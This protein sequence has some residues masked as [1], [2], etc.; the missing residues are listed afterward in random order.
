M[1]SLPP[2]IHPDSRN[3]LPVVRRD[4][5]EESVRI[6]YDE[7][8]TRSATSVAGLQG[9]GGIMLNSPALVAPHR[10]YNRALRTLPELGPALTELAILVAARGMD[11]AFEW[12]T[13]EREALQAGLDARTIEVVRRGTA[14]STA[15]RR[16]RQS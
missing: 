6:A 3:R 12:T 5:L 7:I 16:A 2:D 15:C 13:H 8:A 14:R 4:E 1:A 10:A 9:P 11:Q